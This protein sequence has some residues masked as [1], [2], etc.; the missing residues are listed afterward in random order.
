MHEMAPKMARAHLK[1][2]PPTGSSKWPVK[3]TDAARAQTTANPVLVTIRKIAAT[4][5]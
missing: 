4:N 1:T 2:M 3:I 5:T